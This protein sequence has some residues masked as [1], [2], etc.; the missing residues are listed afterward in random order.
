[1]GL[2]M[3]L[4]AEKDV[5]NYD[6]V[7]IKGEL[8]RVE[9]SEYDKIITA[10]GMDTLPTSQYPS[11]SVRK[12]VAYWRKANAIHGWFVREL[13][14]GKD[15]CQ[16]IYVTR[17]DLVNL[18]NECV[19][20]L[21]NRANAVPN[22]ESSRVI[23]LNDN[24]NNVEEVMTQ[25][26][27]TF[28]KEAQKSNSTIVVSEPLAPTEGFFFGGTEKDEYYYGTIEYTLDTLNALLANGDKYEYYYRASW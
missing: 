20:A 2:D 8:D 14:N 5:S 4:Y 18:R 13:A 1:M 23:K 16:E 24:G 10:S 9:N 19:N 22:N 27:S 26:M 28:K 12:K 11:V 6:Y 15:E 3:Y 17:E 21:A 25:M 7:T